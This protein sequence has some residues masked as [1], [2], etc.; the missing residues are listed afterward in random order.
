MW[1]SI[2]ASISSHT[3]SIWTQCMN[4]TALARI[5]YW[6]YQN[7]MLYSFLLWQ[8]FSFENCALAAA[9]TVSSVRSLPQDFK[10]ALYTQ[11]QL[12]FHPCP[13][14]IDVWYTILGSGGSMPSLFVLCNN[15]NS[16]HWGQPNLF[17]PET[18]AT[19]FELLFSCVDILSKTY[20]SAR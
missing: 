13:R 20:R 7:N 17:V 3:R 2:S 19:T 12:V 6:V 1:I 18:Q 11:V 10:T 9:H 5:P 15:Q 16:Q 8:L 4:T 14:R